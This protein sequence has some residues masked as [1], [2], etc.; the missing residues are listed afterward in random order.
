MSS[1]L[2]TEKNKS[3]LLLAPTLMFILIAFFDIEVILIDKTTDM[4]TTGFSLIRVVE[5]VSGRAER[6]GGRKD[7]HMH[8]QEFRKLLRG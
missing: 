7:I 6:C 3:F 4:T 5:K 1:V 2:I 8:I